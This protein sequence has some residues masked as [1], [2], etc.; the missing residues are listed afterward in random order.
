MVMEKVL[1]RIINRQY[2]GGKKQQT[3]WGA[4]AQSNL[5][6]MYYEGDSVAQDYKQI[7]YWVK[8]TADRLGESGQ[9]HEN[10]ALALKKL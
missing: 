4:S 6:E 2:I 10:A 9:G 8:K 5:G 7:V 3:K 1:I